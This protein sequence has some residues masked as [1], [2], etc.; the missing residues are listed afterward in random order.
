MHRCSE[1]IGT[2]AAALAKA[3]AE[4]TNPEKSL[5]AP[6]DPPSPVKETAASATPRCRAVWTLSAKALAAMRSRQSK[7]PQSTKMPGFF[8]SPL[9]LLI[10]PANG[11]L[12]NGPCVR[13]PIWP[14]RSEWERH[15]LKPG[16]MRCS[17]SSALLGKMIS[18]RRTSMQHPK[19]ELRSRTD[20]I[21]ASNQP[22]IR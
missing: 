14:R 10:R 5:V 11:S 12:R 2:I 9:S 6:S 22:T 4:L 20:P 17:R 7:R 1:T 19:P 3:Q 21:I 18:T 16:A 13:S 15:S 8:A